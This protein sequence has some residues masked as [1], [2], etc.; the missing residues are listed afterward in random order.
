VRPPAAT[1]FN[2]ASF[3][4]WRGHAR[5]LQQRQ[6]RVA[7]G[8]DSRHGGWQNWTTV[9]LTATLGAGVQQ[10]TLLFDTGGMNFRY[11]RV[12]AVASTGTPGPSSGAA[13]PVPGTIKRKT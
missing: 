12:T 11:A 9:S 6:Q 4:G 10:M 7:N 8:L 13:A 1:S 2:C 5:R 3:A